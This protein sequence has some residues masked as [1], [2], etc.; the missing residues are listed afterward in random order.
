M[1]PGDVST[2]VPGAPGHQVNWDRYRRFLIACA[3]DPRFT[4][5]TLLAEIDRNYSLPHVR[6]DALQV[7]DHSARAAYAAGA[8]GQRICRPP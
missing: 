1:R 8:G 7:G 5:G 6:T 4:S 2:I 3:F